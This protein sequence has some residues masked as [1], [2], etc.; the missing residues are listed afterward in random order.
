MTMALASHLDV[1]KSLHWADYLTSGADRLGVTV[2][3]HACSLLAQHACELLVWNRRI[4]LTTI[5]EPYAMAE[6]HYIDSLAAVIHI[7][8][9][10]SLLDIGAG[11]GFPGIPLK[12]VRPDIQVALIDARARKVSFL[13]HAIRVIGLDGAEAVHERIDPLENKAPRF[14]VVI[15]RALMAVGEFID[16][17]SGFCRPGGAIVAMQGKQGPDPPASVR[18]GRKKRTLGAALR[19]DTVAYHLPYSRARRSITIVTL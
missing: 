4:N 16:L 15:S 3:A 6:K 1:I 18:A 14:D 7:P 9:G 10:A 2:S 17:A 13:K 11:G 8:Q 19:V 5:T 12:I